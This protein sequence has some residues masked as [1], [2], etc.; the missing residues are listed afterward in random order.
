MQAFFKRT[1]QIVAKIDMPDIFTKEK[2]SEVMRAIKGKGTGLE[3]ETAKMLRRAR[4][5][6]RSHPKIF[7][8]PDFIV[9]G[10]LLLFCDGSFW[11]G[12]DWKKLKKRLEAGNDPGYWVKHIESNR[13]RD[14]KVNKVLRERGYVV[15][16]LWDTDIKRR[17]ERCVSKIRREL[18]SNRV[19]A[20]D[21]AVS[22]NG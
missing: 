11:H 20:S 21:S 3:K 6:Y 17:P 15:L 10:R 7:G 13:K 1:L 5:K 8:S 12:N 16:R 14:R 18:R 19:T 22:M 9:E 2:R 4:I